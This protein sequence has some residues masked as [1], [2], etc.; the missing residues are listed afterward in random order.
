V[1]AD[2]EVVERRG[3]DEGI[4]CDDLVGDH[5]DEGE[6]VALLGRPGWRGEVARR[7]GAGPGIGREWRAGQ[8]ASTHG[9]SGCFV[10]QAATALSATARL[11]EPSVRMLASTRCK[12]A[13][14]GTSGVCLVRLTICL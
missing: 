1:L 8:V 9:A 7:D 12:Q 5:G 14:E 11:T 10:D 6:R 4:G 13:M 2:A 3:E